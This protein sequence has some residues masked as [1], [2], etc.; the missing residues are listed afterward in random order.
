[1]S[2]QTFHLTEFH[3]DWV[4]AHTN[5]PLVDIEDNDFINLMNWTA[6]DMITKR[7]GSESKARSAIESDDPISIA[8]YSKLEETPFELM[9]QYGHITTPLEEFLPS[10]EMKAFF[11]NVK[12]W[13]N[14]EIEFNPEFDHFDLDGNFVKGIPND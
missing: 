13:S 1:M 3:A 6:F 4:C 2:G 8:E 11:P 9:S 10:E 12:D 5:K 7:L 14:V